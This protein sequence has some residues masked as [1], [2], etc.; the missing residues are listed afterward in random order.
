MEN[1]EVCDKTSN[2][3]YFNC[4][5]LMS[6]GRLFT[7]YRPR[8]NMEN[9]IIQDG[10]KKGTLNGLLNNTKGAISYQEYLTNNAV[11]I[12]N[13]QWEYTHCKAGCNVKPSVQLMPEQ[14]KCDVNTSF[15]LCKINNNNGV[16]VVYNKFFESPLSKSA[17]LSAPLEKTEYYNLNN[18][19]SKY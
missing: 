15:S 2:N 1:K 8:N 18:E 10:M 6:D 17:G 13:R 5:P 16:G 14:V 9:I 3:K 12:M 7:D 11:N 19:Y 4:P